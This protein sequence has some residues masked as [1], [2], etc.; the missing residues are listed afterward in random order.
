MR[1]ACKRGFVKAG[2][3]QHTLRRADMLRFAAM[4]G[5]GKGNLL[6]SQSKSIGRTGFDQ[7]KR[8]QRLDGGTRIDRT[9]RVTDRKNGR[10]GH[11]HNGDGAA[12]A[13]LDQCSSCRFNEYRIGHCLSL[14]L[15]RR[16]KKGRHSSVGKLG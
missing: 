11:V 4:R 14:P 13:T 15:S 2:A 12:M 6:L 3:L 9:V 8:L 7:R 1:P 5:A 16:S 10:P